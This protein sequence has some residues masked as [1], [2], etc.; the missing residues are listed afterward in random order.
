MDST[1]TLGLGWIADHPD[2]HDYHPEHPEVSEF[3]K[4]RNLIGDSVDPPLGGTFDISENDFSPVENQRSLG[5]CTAQAGV[6]LIEY[7]QKKTK[8]KFIDMSRLFLYKATRNMLGWT[9]DTGAYLRTTMGAMVLFGV[10]PERYMPY[11]ISK[12]DEEPSAFLYSFAK[13]FQT[14]R[15]L[16][17]DP[18]GMPKDKL[19]QRIKSMINRKMPSMFGFTVYNS[20]SQ[21]QN[22]QGEIPFPCDTDR[23]TGGHAVI[24]MGYDDQKKIRNSNCGHETVGAI[25]IR[26]SWGPNW[27]DGGYGWIPYDYVLRGLAVD[28]WTLIRNEWINTDLFK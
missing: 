20:I 21:A 9:G 11:D 7:Y 8:G 25:K 10:P 4:E 18:Q 13:E 23:V 27:G 14:I 19:L 12:Y 28:W 2:I 5:S 22:N 16:R 17:L 26:N 6:G 24:A 15:Y 3:F 1:N